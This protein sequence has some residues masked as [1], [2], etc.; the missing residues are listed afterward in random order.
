MLDTLMS[1]VGWFFRIAGPLALLWLLLMVLRWLHWESLNNT[2]IGLPI[3]FAFLSLLT[4]SPTNAIFLLYLSV[5]CTAG[6]SLV[7]WLPLAWAIGR[8]VVQVIGA[9]RS[10]PASGRT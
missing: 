7:L 9:M 5:V 1:I 3:L 2:L 10:G 8:V 4:G 6:V